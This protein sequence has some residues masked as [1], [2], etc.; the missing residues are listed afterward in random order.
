MPWIYRQTRR[1][2][3]RAVDFYFLDL[4]VTGE[5]PATGPLLI[6]C[7]H[8]NSIMDTLVLGSVVEREIHFLARSGLFSNPFVGAFLRSAGAIPIYRRQDGPADPAG[9]EDAFRAAYEVLE[10]GEVIGIFP[11][12]QN[13]PIRHVRDIKTGVARIGLGAEALHHAGVKIVPVGLNYEERDRF[14]AR[15]LVRIGEPIEVRE[16][17]EHEDGA[18][19]L[20]NVVQERMRK[21]AVHVVDM[22]QTDF[23]HAIDALVG[24]DLQKELIGSIDLRTI[25]EKLLQRAVGRGAKHADLEGRFQ[26]RQW[27]ADAVEY[28]EVEDPEAVRTLQRDIERYT[29]H[30]RQLR[31]RADF[32]D[33]PAKT[34][35]ARREALRWTTYAIALAPVALWGLVHNFI[36]YRLTRRFA[37]G[38]NEEAIRAIRAVLGSFLFF[39]LFYALYGGS[40]YGGTE[41][42]WA[43]ALYLFSLPIAGVWYLRYVQRL[44]LF[45]SRILVR[46]LFRTR[47]RLFRSLLLEREQLLVRIDVMKRAYRAH[48]A[49]SADESPRGE[50]SE[51]ESSPQ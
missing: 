31:L 7:N 10:R 2:F 41:R 19:A 45:R 38:A 24:E 18:R 16:W 4:Q 25:D 8:P 21:L 47:R 46:T 43:V 6:A 5:V 12:G 32:A 39:G 49:S 36:P 13:A 9:N 30:L 27:I 23:V 1:V 11:E 34:L 3:R 40:V 37:M 29:A 42:W 17:L 51:S 33:R 20:T 22:E 26:V 14:L 44:R 28:F 15:V 48:R 35:S 50:S